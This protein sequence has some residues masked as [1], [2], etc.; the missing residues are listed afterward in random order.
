MLLRFG[1]VAGLRAETETGVNR[2][3]DARLDFGSVCFGSGSEKS[4]CAGAVLMD[5]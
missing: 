2:S 5:E 4:L 3:T 1:C